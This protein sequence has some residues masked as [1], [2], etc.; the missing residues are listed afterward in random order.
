MTR[1]VL[2]QVLRMVTFILWH[3]SAQMSPGQRIRKH[4]RPGW[5]AYSAS[6]QDI[7][8]TCLSYRPM[9][10]NVAPLQASCARGIQSFRRKTRCK[11][12]CYINCNQKISKIELTKRQKR[13]MLV[14]N[15]YFAGAIGLKSLRCRRRKMSRPTA[16]AL[17]SFATQTPG[18]TTIPV[19]LYVALKVCLTILMMWRKNGRT[20]FRC[21]ARFRIWLAAFPFWITY[22]SFPRF[23]VLLRDPTIEQG[24]LKYNKAAC[25]I[26]ESST[27]IECGDFPAISN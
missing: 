25:S 10:V 17:T 15:P 24:N 19:V 9:M 1:G 7:S 5:T 21:Q 6:C 20:S 23:N 12:G 14:Y 11:C 26:I 27:P 2:S 13:K 22:S 3:T 16:F 18:V 8:G 4:L